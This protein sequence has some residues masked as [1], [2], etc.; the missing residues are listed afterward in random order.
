MTTDRNAVRRA[1]C[2]TELEG[3]GFSRRAFLSLG[4]L[5]AC[6][7]ALVGRAAAA[8]AVAVDPNLSVFL[9]DIHVSGK[10]VK[11]QPTYQNPL[12]AKVVRQVLAMNPRPKNALVFGDIALWNGWSR[13]YA[14][15]AP[16]IRTLADAGIDVFLTAG[17]HDH[18]EPLLRFHPRQKE[19][20]PVPGRLVSVVDL[21]TADFVLLD[22][23]RENPEGE[24][25]GNAVNGALDEAQADWLLDF[26]K[27]AR[28]PFFCGA[29]HP[30]RELVVR[31]AKLLQLLEDN[32]NFAGYVHGHNHRWSKEW[33]H[34]GFSKAHIVRSACLPSTGW[35]GNIGF[36]TFRTQ[37]DR[38][39]LAFVQ[40]DFFFP[41]PLAPERKR[42][43][44]WDQIMREAEGDV[45]AFPYG[46]QA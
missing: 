21:G 2:G 13:D 23:L 20:T 39:T 1:P 4:S 7:G 15:S 37:A 32:P 6:A 40:N 43:A 10:D 45:C 5:A 8:D 16:L 18:R 33:H 3:G 14:E 31:G 36:A 41:R 44:A 9:S 46:R 11:G 26:A 29:H 19:L 34:Y 25:T 24:G 27:A 17:N 42:P 28:R 30:S 38:A 35:W 22:T 12:F